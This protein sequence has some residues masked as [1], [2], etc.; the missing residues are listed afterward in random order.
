MNKETPDMLSVATA[1]LGLVVRVRRAL[2][3]RGSEELAQWT[4]LFEQFNYSPREFYLLVEKNLETRKIPGS[5]T[6]PLALRQGG[7]LSPERLYLAIRRE[8]LVFVLCAAPFGSGFF[9]S[10][11]LLDYRSGA[12]LFDV[13]FV[14]TVLLG[15][16]FGAFVKWGF[17]PGVFTM[18]FFITLFWSLFRQ[19][20]EVG[21]EW[22]DEKMVT[23]PVVGRVYETLFCPDTYYRRDTAEMFRQAVTSAVMQ[24]IDEMTTEKGIHGL[25]QEER[26]PVLRNLYR[27]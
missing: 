20:A 8:R 7:I 15:I 16:G 2:Q 3:V 23:M 21:S 12:N 27:K 18:G 10:S 1:P 5:G 4:K 6:E 9:V 25:T 24:A 17:V 19:A 11:R 26:K 13:L 22:L 14:I